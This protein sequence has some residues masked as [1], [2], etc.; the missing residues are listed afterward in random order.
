LE[1]LEPCTLDLGTAF[2]DREGGGVCLPALLPLLQ[3]L[4]GE[5]ERSR[6]LRLGLLRRIAP[7]REPRK[8]GAYRGEIGF[9]TLDV[10]GELGECRLCL[11]QLIALALAQ[12]AGVLDRLLEAR[13]VRAHF[14]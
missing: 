2:R 3:C 4:F 10:L 5:L 13:D 9:V 8:L 1:L 14:V 6:G 12:L 7:G 11:R